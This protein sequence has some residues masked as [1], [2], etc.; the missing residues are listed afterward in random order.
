MMMKY[1]T[2]S[3]NIYNALAVS[4]SVMSLFLLFMFMIYFLYSTTKTGYNL[5]YSLFLALEIVTMVVG[6]FFAVKQIV[7]NK[8]LEAVLSIMLLSLS[9]FG[10]LIM[11]SV[12]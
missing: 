4:F 1:K 6:T 8:H 11:I 10:L 9:F 3:D 2:K 12:I 5:I 7:R